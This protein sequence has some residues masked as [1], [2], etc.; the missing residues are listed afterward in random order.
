MDYIGATKY[1]NGD[2]ACMN[3]LLRCTAKN[4]K[5]HQA[6]INHGNQGLGLTAP[7]MPHL[8]PRLNYQSDNLSQSA[9]ANPTNMRLI[10]AFAR[11]VPE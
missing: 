2:N 3:T 5:N 7:R 10:Q 1:T 8:A 6:V 4:D 9:A 11:N